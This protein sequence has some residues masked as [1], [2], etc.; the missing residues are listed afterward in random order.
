MYERLIPNFMSFT[1]VGLMIVAMV[2]AGVAEEAGL[3]KALIRKLVLV[4]PPRAL[5]YIMAF[6]GIMSSIAADAGYL[7][8]IPLAGAAYLSVNRNPIAGLALGFAAVASA[9]TVNMLIKPLDAVLVEFTNDAIHLVDPKASIGL[10]SNLW[11]SIVSVV[12]LTGLIAFITERTI[13]PRLGPI[14]G[15]E[16]RHQGRGPAG[17]FCGMNSTVARS[18]RARTRSGYSGNSP[19]SV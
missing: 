2:G 9:F 15:R 7:V 5:T 16:Q 3:V 13:E 6:V 18:F 14:Q 19:R 12:I 17:G 10:T 8:L 1:A 4:A 11:F